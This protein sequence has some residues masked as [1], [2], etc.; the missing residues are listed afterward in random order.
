MT[1]RAVPRRTAAAAELKR[2][3][4]AVGTGRTGRPHTN[5]V[6]AGPFARAL[7]GRIREWRLMAGLT[8]RQVCARAPV[9]VNVGR[10]SA[11]ERGAH[12]PRASNLWCVAVAL[13]VAVGDLA[14]AEG[15]G[16]TRLLSAED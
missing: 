6:G 4:A 11:W 7:G 3:H 2:R 14:P 15:E 9:P 16:L 8:L 13:D 1:K 5:P 12:E 10:W